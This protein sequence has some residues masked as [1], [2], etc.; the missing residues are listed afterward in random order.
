MVATVATHHRARLA[1]LGIQAHVLRCGPKL[2]Q[3]SPVPLPTGPIRALCVARDVPKKGLDDLLQAWEDAPSGSRLR[4]LSDLQRPDLPEGVEILG[5]RPPAEVRKEMAESNLFI[6]PC[7]RAPDGDLDGIPVA[8]MEA[9]ACGR[10]VITTPVSGI[11]ELVDEEVGWL[12]PA[13]NVPS[14]AK[15]IR[16]ASDHGE[17]ERRGSRG[18]ERLR[19]R[20]FT[21]MAQAQGLRSLW[22]KSGV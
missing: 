4:L 3:W 11:P 19:S 2:E 15:A 17:R 1:E 8:I 7:K 13:G 20:A 10:P 16:S 6:L 21:L 5:L 9:L 18:P 12:V 22:G 14:L